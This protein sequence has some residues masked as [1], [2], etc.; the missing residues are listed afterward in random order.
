[1][2]PSPLIEHHDRASTVRLYLNL[3]DSC[4]LGQIEQ[5]ASNFVAQSN[6]LGLASIELIHS[7]Y[8]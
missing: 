1:V 8:S 7:A 6:G 3:P 2:R 4:D 5:L